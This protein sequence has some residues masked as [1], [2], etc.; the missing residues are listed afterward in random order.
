MKLKNSII[1]IFL[2]LIPKN[3]VSN[4]MGKLVSIKWPKKMALFINKAFVGIFNININ[5]AE[6]PLTE[7]ETLQDLFIRRLK[8]GAREASQGDNIFSPCDG[9]LSVFGAIKDDELIQAK[10]RMYS[11]LN[12]LEDKELSA[13][14]KD[15]F[16]A[17]IYLSPKDYHRFHMPVDGHINKTIY[18]P[19]AL[20]PVNKWAVNNIQDLFCQNERVISLVSPSGK[21]GFIAHVAVGATMVGKIDLDYCKI[22]EYKNTR[23]KV[24]IDHGESI[25]LSK[26]DDL[27]KFMFGSTIILLISKNL[28]EGFS[29][30]SPAFIKVNQLLARWR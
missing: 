26:G 10:G 23:D 11:L 19:G 30:D 1:Y 6:K 8:P 3:L 5:E 24:I 7:Y 14:F 20:W 18:I 16:F 4:L 21:S 12:L 28:I 13:K 17:T 9:F 2:Y 22:P 29:S 25:Y 15:G 27:G